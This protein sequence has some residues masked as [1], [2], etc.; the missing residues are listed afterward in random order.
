M[1][2]PTAHVPAPTLELRDGVPVST[3]FDDVYFS[4]AGGAAETEYVFLHGNGLPKRWQEKNAFT[5]GELGFGTGLNFLVTL[6]AFR[7]T[8]NIQA[9]LHY[10][11]IE[12]FPFMPEQLRELL[13][14]QP[15]LAM[16]VEELL[17][18][19]PLRLPGIHRLH[20]GNV[21]LTLCF[22]DVLEMLREINSPI[23]A[24]YLDGFS[25]AKNGEMWDENMYQHMQRLSAPD[26]TVATF[27]AASHVRRGL[28][29][30][31]FTVTKTKGFGHKREMS[32]GVFEGGVAKHCVASHGEPA[33]R[34]FGGKAPIN[35]II[36]IGAGIAGATL[37]RALAERG[38]AVTILE[39]YAI[40]SGASGNAAGVLFPQIT[41]QW[42]LASDWYFTAYSYALRQLRHW[43]SQGLV[44]E[45][46]A[47]GML[48]LPRHAD[49]EMLLQHLADTH[50]LDASIVHWL[51]RDAASAQAG[52]S[53]QTGAAFFPEGTWLN[54]AQ[55]CAALVQ[56]KHITLRAQTGVK[57]L[58]RV[59]ECWQLTL[60]GGE[61]LETKYCCMTAAHESAALLGNY[62]LKLGAV[63]GQVSMFNAADA[64][65]PLRSILCHS[66]YVIP[67]GGR[68]LVGATYHREDMLSVTAERHDENRA[69][70]NEILPG[71]MHSDAV[72]GRSS[73]R[74]TTPDRLPY[75]GALNDGLYVSTG[76]GSRGLLS[77]PLAAEMIA[78]R[79]AGETSPVS[80]ALQHIT[81]PLRFNKA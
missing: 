76:H 4:R 65:S 33:G 16:Q 81:R 38:Y 20:L 46:A 26:A 71:W 40:A 1:T 13:A 2:K 58:A 24:W 73:A 45:H 39:H 37:A 10:I 57:S 25:P 5:V 8:A 43:Q 59:G 70:L 6:K 31:G 63:G 72:D 78:S 19:Y 35:K 44:F 18:V 80:V 74:A 47:C 17:A 15:E 69:A 75:V 50:G 62:G 67:V 48:R 64:A 12:K 28:K 32:S 29:A 49:E 14:Q 36:I 53:L 54:P 79:I 23:D 27:T 21:S 7:E 66:G 3:A 52:V 60:A 55:L 30:A 11:A 34:G 61:V 22:G 68:I 42:G 77:A 9:R 56:H 51:G 41:K